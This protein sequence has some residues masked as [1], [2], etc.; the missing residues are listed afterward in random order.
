[1]ATCS[2]VRIDNGQAF[3]DSAEIVKNDDGSVSFQL[4]NGE[5]AGQ[6]PNVYGMRHDGPAKQQYQRASLVGD[7]ASFLTR[8]RDL[9]C[10]Y[11]CVQGKVFP[12]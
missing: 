1:M 3:V 12:S 8:P 5:F 11:L 7:L 4:P 6:E 2:L 9:V 10:G